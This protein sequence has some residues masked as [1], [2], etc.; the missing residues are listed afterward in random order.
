MTWFCEKNLALHIA[1]GF[2][3]LVPVLNAPVEA[4]WGRFPAAHFTVASPEAVAPLHFEDP[5][6]G[7]LGR[8]PSS[9]QDADPSAF[10][11]MQ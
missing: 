2:N 7:Q 9:Q 4:C 5:R 11:S 1:V 6:E 10:L 8:N 3:I